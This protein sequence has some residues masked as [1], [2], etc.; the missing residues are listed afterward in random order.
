MKKRNIILGAGFTALLAM[1]ITG[2]AYGYG[3][4]YS[5]EERLAH[6]TDKISRELKLDDQQ[7]AVLQDIASAFKSK[8]IDMK[9]TRQQMHGDAIALIGQD[10]VTA[11]EVAELIEQHR[12]NWD[13]MAVF[14]SEQLARFHGILTP[15]QRGLLVEAIDRHALNGR[16]CRFGRSS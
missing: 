12:R 16:H 11:Q 4:F 14:A 8:L 13:E 1:L 3:Q 5:P 2:I 15:E 10:A 7:Q 9:E 6:L